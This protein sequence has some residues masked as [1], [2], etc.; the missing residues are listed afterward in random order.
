MPVDEAMFSLTDALGADEAFLTS[1]TAPML[2]VVTI[3]GH[4]VGTGKP[5]PVATRLAALVN[6]EL[7]RQT[8]WRG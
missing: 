7:A 2:P 5:G 3:D 4:K 1:T 8:G 6:A